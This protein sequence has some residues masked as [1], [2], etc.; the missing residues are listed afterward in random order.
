MF[1]LQPM[2]ILERDKPMPRVERKL[3]EFNVQSYRP[4]YE[5]YI[6]QAVP[7]IRK[8]EEDMVKRVGAEFI[9]LTEIYDQTAEQSFTD[10]AHLTPRANEMLARIVAQRLIPLLQHRLTTAALPSRDP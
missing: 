8:Q 2:L 3:F 4:G 9:D 10:Y 6:H 7:F 5:A 1:M